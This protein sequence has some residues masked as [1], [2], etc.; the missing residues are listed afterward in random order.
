AAR[1]DELLHE[2]RVDD[3]TTLDDAL[4][5][6]EKVVHIRDAAL[7][8][9]SAPLAADEEIH[10]MLYFDVG[11]EHEYPEARILRAYRVRRLETFRRVCRRH[12]DVDDQQ[13]GLVLA[14]RPNRG[15]PIVG[16]SDNV[17]ARALQEAGKP[18]PK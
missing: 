7:Q 4:E 16:L 17:E 2:G 8:Q 3:G 14:A 5:R 18:F 6:L 15:R 12:A 13:V 10:R 1:R 9:I 11:R